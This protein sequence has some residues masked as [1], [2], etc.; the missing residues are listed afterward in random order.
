MLNIMNVRHICCSS[1]QCGFR[2]L[3]NR[4]YMIANELREQWTITTPKATMKKKIYY[5]HCDVFHTICYAQLIIQNILLFY[6]SIHMST[7]LLFFFFSV[8]SVVRNFNSRIHNVPNVCFYQKPFLRNIENKKKTVYD[9]V[10][11]HWQL[12]T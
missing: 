9:A 11:D 10:T 6:A 12:S 2:K 5:H 4:R 7:M 8:F 1:D 3:I